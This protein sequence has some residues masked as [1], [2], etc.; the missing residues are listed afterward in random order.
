M[1]FLRTSEVASKIGLSRSTLWRMERSGQF[2][3][4]RQIAPGA[5]GWLEQEVEAWMKQREILSSDEGAKVS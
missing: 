3:K 1:R 4:R 5:V 2:P